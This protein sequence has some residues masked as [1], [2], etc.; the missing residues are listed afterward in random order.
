MRSKRVAIVVMIGFPVFEKD[1]VVGGIVVGVSKTLSEWFQCELCAPEKSLPVVRFELHLHPLAS[2]R[3]VVG[4]E[5]LVTIRPRPRHHCA[6]VA[7]Q[8]GPH[9]VVLVRVDLRLSEIAQVAEEPQQIYIP[10]QQRVSIFHRRV[11][12]LVAKLIDCGHS[13][14]CLEDLGATEEEFVQGVVMNF[15]RRIRSQCV[16]IVEEGH[17]ALCL[18][19]WYY[20]VGYRLQCRDNILTACAHVNSIG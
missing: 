5:A 15:H 9:A 8:R 16:F 7:R 2:V 20:S 17:V 19:F 10:R 13:S 14:N 6:V 18:P 4:V 1:L 12:G 11:T 3:P